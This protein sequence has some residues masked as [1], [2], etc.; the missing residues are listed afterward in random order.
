[1]IFKVIAFIII[2]S[3]IKEMDEAKE[4]KDLC[5]IVYWG[6]LMTITIMVMGWA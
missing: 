6:I 1:M 2:L 3:I 5:D 4:K